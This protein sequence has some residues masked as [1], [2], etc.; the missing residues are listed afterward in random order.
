MVDT[1]NTFCEHQQ[2]SSFLSAF[3]KLRKA[4]VSVVMSV[5]LSVCLR[6][7]TQLPLDGFSWNLIF[8]SF[9]KIYWENSR[10]IKIGQGYWVL[11]TKT[12][13]FFLSYY[14]LFFLEWELFQTKVVEKIKTNILDEQFFSPKIPPFMRYVEKYCRAGQATDDNIAHARCMLDT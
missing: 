3:A 5:R 6:G 4:T 7:T 9:S 14:A 11:Y 1:L 13:I 10:F 2:L 8:E 12:N